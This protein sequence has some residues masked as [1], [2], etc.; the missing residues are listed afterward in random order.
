MLP[1]PH[2]GC[3]KHVWVPLKNLLKE[4]GKKGLFLVRPR[5]T[6]SSRSK[7]RKRPAMR[8]VI[9]TEPAFSPH[10]QFEH[11]KRRRMRIQHKSVCFRVLCS[12]CTITQM[13]WVKL[14]AEGLCIMV[15]LGRH[16]LHSNHKSAHR[17]WA[18]IHRSALL[19]VCASSRQLV[20]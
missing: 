7:V 12:N 18:P 6:H 8:L 15:L 1:R 17:R 13:G 16:F 4:T 19:L 20:S 14:R 11:P 2:S 5:Q 9:C 3:T 10:R